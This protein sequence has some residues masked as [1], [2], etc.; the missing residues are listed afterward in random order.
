MAHGELP[1]V[2]THLVTGA[3]GFVGAAIV[4]ELLEQTTDAVVAIVRPGK[5][6]AQARFRDALAQAL[7]VYGSTLA[8][9][10]ALARCRV[11]AG[12]VATDCCGIAGAPLGRVTQV[13][14]CA[15]SLRYEDRYAAEIEATNVDGTR[16]VLALATS[17]GAETFN[18]VST[19]YV[20]GRRNGLIA[21]QP[22]TD[23]EP[24]NFYEA[25]KQQAERLVIATS[26][27]RIRVFRPSVVVGHSRTLAATTFSGYYGFVRQIVQFRG[28]VE[29]VQK[30][31]LVRS[32]VKL[33]I[34]PEGLIN[35]VPID[36]VAREAVSIAMSGASEGV[37][38]LTHAAPP[39]IGLAIRTVF[40]M[41][42]LHE[43]EFVR[44]GDELGWLDQK[45]DDRLE[46]Y[47]SYITANRHFD[48]SRT[49]AALGERRRADAAYD[50]ASIEALGRWY[51]A[52]L[53]RERA[54]LPVAR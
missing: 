47:R 18:Y 31:L 36:T 17:L 48:R 53:E 10:D 5:A 13:W 4:V 24:N 27:P 42:G 6:G 25:S 14:H 21:E 7:E 9:E 39:L 50:G 45:L 40:S 19:A 49:D 46:F 41:L 26:G 29:R 52:R 33:R 20:A 51:L 3:T 2:P 28:M 38:H 32:P 43:P 44:D 37:Y 1:P 22:V 23:V 35:L 54:A 12:D 11:V 30:G 34:D 16:N 15:A 8:L